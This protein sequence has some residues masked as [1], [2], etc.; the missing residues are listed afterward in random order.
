MAKYRIRLD[1]GVYEWGLD[2]EYDDLSAAK[3]EAERIAS[4]SPTHGHIS[5]WRIDTHEVVAHFN[6]KI[7][8]S[9]EG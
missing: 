7:P 2:T 9:R 8:Q 1:D 4:Q 5:V 6:G 3:A